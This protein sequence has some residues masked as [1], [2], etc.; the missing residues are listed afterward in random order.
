M[1]LCT[2][3]SAGRGMSRFLPGLPSCPII[4]FIADRLYAMLAGICSK[5]CRSVVAAIGPPLDLLLVKLVR[6]FRKHRTLTR[7]LVLCSGILKSC[8]HCE[9]LQT[10]SNRRRSPAPVSGKPCTTTECAARLAGGVWGKAVV[11]AA[12][13]AAAA[14]TAASQGDDA[15][16]SGLLH[17]R[18]LAYPT[19]V[20][21]T[22][23]Q[24]GLAAAA[25]GLAPPSAPQTAD[26]RQLCVA[27]FA[28]GGNGNGG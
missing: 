25:A 8:Y 17:L 16:V 9:C 24:T 23:A 15:D 3:T 1:R 6:V 4:Y 22:V 28:A 21:V 7:R 26:R 19:A 27:H 20:A 13:V 18:T 14:G 12:A 10:L 2:S 11:V 5:N